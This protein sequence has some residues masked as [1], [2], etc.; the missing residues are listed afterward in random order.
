MTRR[1][2]LLFF[3]PA[4]LVFAVFVLLPSTQTL[5]DSFYQF[6]GKQRAFAGALYYRFALSDPKFHQSLANNVIYIGWTLL[7]EV[8]VGLALAVALERE[9][10]LNNFLRIAFFSP[11]VL[12]LVVNGP[13]FGFRFKVGVGVWPCMLDESRAVLTLTMKTGS[14]SCGHCIGI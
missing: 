9:N 13:V 14:P 12:S 5:L 2:Q 3:L 1:G 4:L 8:I 11:S 10:R 7:F 6:H